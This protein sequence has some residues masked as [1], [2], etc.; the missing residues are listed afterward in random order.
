MFVHKSL[1]VG[2]V[3]DIEIAFV[4]LSNQNVLKF[5]ANLN[6]VFASVVLEALGAQNARYFFE[7]VE[8]ICTVEKGFSLKQLEMCEKVRV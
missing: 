3:E 6:V 2:V 1:I 7:L 5:L 8:F 4:M